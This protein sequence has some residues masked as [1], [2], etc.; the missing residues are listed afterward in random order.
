MTTE[1]GIVVGH[2]IRLFDKA[3]FGA[4]LVSAFSVH[5]VVP[6]DVINGDRNRSGNG[7]SAER[8]AAKYHFRRAGDGGM[9]R[10]KWTSTRTRDDLSVSCRWHCGESGAVCRDS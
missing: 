10:D 8:Q 2:M 5:L 3:I 1:D 6:S 7:I 9:Y 4:R